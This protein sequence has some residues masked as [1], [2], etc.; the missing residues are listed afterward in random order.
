LKPSESAVFE[1]VAG[2]EGGM[3]SAAQD[4]APGRLGPHRSN[5][6][7]AVMCPRFV[8][9][10]LCRFF[11]ANLMVQSNGANLEERVGRLPN[12]DGQHSRLFRWCLSPSTFKHDT[13]SKQSNQI[14]I[15]H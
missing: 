10:K 7:N 9:F 8:I 4:A 14:E 1:N 11:D 13:A 2:L 3:V 6:C 5:T 12:V 15:K